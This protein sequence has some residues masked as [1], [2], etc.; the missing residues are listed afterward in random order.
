MLTP[1]EKIARYML[2]R[3][4]KHGKSLDPRDR[5]HLEALQGEMIAHE[6]VLVNERTDGIENDLQDADAE[7]QKLAEPKSEAK[8]EPKS[9][10]K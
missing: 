7:V 2:A 6:R 8:S 3:E 10:K 4:L 1:Y 5:A 9:D